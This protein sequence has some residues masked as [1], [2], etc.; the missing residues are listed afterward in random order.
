MSNR[1]EFL[2]ATGGALAL[3]P[4]GLLAESTA[5]VAKPIPGTDENLPA[6]GLG[7]NRYAVGDEE[8]NARLLDNHRATLFP[9]RPAS[10]LYEAP[11]LLSLLGALA[12]ASLRQGGLARDELCDL[13]FRGGKK[14][15]MLRAALFGPPSAA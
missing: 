14:F 10:R 8:Q 9:Q 15:G 2:Q 6:I 5:L 12:T 11:S 13:A 7:T 4:A 3:G 1:R